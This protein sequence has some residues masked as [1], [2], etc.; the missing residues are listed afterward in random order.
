MKIYFSLFFYFFIYGCYA[1]YI[2]VDTSL[3]PQQLVQ[4][5]LAGNCTQISNVTFS[6]GDIGNSHITSIG[7][8]SNGNG[9]FPFNNGIILTTGDVNAAPGPNNNIQSAGW[10]NKNDNGWIGDP[11]IA[12]LLGTPTSN[13]HNATILEFNFVPIAS[14]VSFDYL[15]ASEEYT[16]DFPCLYS[17]GFAFIISGPGISATNNYDVDANPNTPDV[18]INLGGKD[19]ALLPNTNIPVSV[20]NIH[21]LINGNKGCSAKN[22]TYFDNINTNATNF[23]GQTVKLTAQ[24]TVIPNKTYHIKLVIAEYIDGNYDTAVFLD[25]NSF[26][27]GINL[28]ED[29]NLCVGTDVTLNADLHIASATYKWY[30]D[31]VLLPSKI[32]PKLQI[33]NGTINDSGNYKV[34]AI[35]N[36][37]ISCIITDNVNVTFNTIP[38]ATKPNDWIVCDD[39]NDGFYTFDLTQKDSEILNLQ[40]PQ[41]FKVSY[42]LDTLFTQPI[43]APT[44]FTNTTKNQQTIYAKVSN[45]NNGSCFASTSFNLIIIDSPK[46]ALATDIPN[47]EVCDNNLDG[48]DTNGIATFN[49]TL[50]NQIILNGQSTT[51][52]KLKYFT[53][54]ALTQPIANPT[55][56]KNTVANGQS[57]FVK[58]A[59][60]K[61][62]TCYATTSFKIVVHPLPIINTMVN[63]KQCDTDTDGITNF[64]LTQSESN[65]NQSND[66][67]LTYSYY[68]KLQDAQIGNPTKEITDTL[69][70]SN[71]NTNKVYVRVENKDGCYRIAQLKL[72]VATTT[73]P[74]NYIVPLQV[75]DDSNE[76]GIST[77]NLNIAKDSILKLF[78]PNQ[79]LKVTFYQNTADA[80]AEI[81]SI[82][83]DNYK[84]TLSP[85]QQTIVVRV[86]SL[87]DNACV[88]F[89]NHV[90]LTVHRL[91]QYDLNAQNILCTNIGSTTISVLN[92]DGSYNYQW[93][94]SSNNMIGTNSS[95]VKID[96]S[97]DYSVIVTKTNGTSCSKE[98]FTNIIESEP[99]KI[100]AISIEDNS[101]NNVISVEISGKG[102]YEIALDDAENYIPFKQNN[103]STHIFT[104]VKSGIH[105][106]YIKDKNGCGLIKKQVAVIGYSKFFTP[107]GD[108]INDYWTIKGI[109]LQPNSLVYIFDRYGRL[110]KILNATSKGWD[111]FYNG[112]QLPSTDYWFKAKLING[113]V[114]KGHFSLIRK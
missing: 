100:N 3:S 61:S 5:V 27:T 111:G 23:N 17:D 62:N 4:N 67:S 46:P 47:L 59:N 40:N 76:D 20:T 95:T 1:Q 11:D 39:N 106:V 49:L 44:A 107:N 66:T 43:T 86:E 69:A 55:T 87:N 101:L 7:S 80:L 45:N 31:G 14:H 57:I 58:M 102:D 98:K 112:N 51:K 74:I 24:A 37:N 99:A 82:N 2:T 25:A 68:L 22:E 73:I 64:N 84:N 10:N 21:K 93:L 105:W 103:N 60:I 36:N 18:P 89:G 97:G 72:L 114:I 32:N 110:I 15:M 63:L 16:Q 42:F 104:D 108:G 30:K 81:N 9:I 50:Q 8:F 56:F 19:I 65:I 113:R 38:T 34:E 6:G 91:P 88:G 29:Q 48:S 75:C 96:K 71:S 26:N 13:T 54:V 12:A 90:K 92:A 52:F 33:T 79:K 70:F 83:Q 77:F 78:P 94:D 109:G 41:N 35:L 28:G 53:D 85:Y